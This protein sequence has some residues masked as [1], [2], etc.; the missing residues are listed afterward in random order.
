[1]SANLDPPGGER[2]PRP[3]REFVTVYEAAAP[4]LYAWIQIRI[5]S[6][7]RHLIDPEDVLQEVWIRGMHRFAQLQDAAANGRGWLFG[8]A[9]N[10]LLEHLRRVDRLPV[11]PDADTLSGSARI[12]RSETVTSIASRMAR[13]E[14]LQR[15]VERVQSLDS[16]DRQIVLLCG[17]QAC[18]CVTAARRLGLGEDLVTKRWQRLRERLRDLPAAR[19]LLLCSE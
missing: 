5:R 15:F 8:I 2:A 18:T 14:A 19:Q 16:E 17:F 13:D 7:L 9:R 10:V 4:L 6:S 1:M 3:G 12:E 11:I